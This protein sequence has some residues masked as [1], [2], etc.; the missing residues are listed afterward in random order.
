LDPAFGENGIVLT[1]IRNGDDHA[2]ALTIQ[3]DGKI[4]AAGNTNNGSDNDFAIIR[5]TE[6]GTFD[7]DFGAGGK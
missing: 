6:S 2:Y 7:P 3:P 5:Y 4:V 1:D